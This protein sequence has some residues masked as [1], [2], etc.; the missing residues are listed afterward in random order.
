MKKIIYILSFLVVCC[1]ADFKAQDI[2][3]SNINEAPLFNSP[4][5]T[6]FYNG[7][8]RFIANY[9]TKPKKLYQAAR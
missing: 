5:N 6:G 3:F 2:H 1:V 9:R 4:A 7:Y 8:F